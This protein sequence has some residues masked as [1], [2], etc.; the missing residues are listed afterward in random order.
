M[1]VQIWS[2]VMCPFCYIGKRRL[3]IALQD[4][5]QRNNVEF[6]YRSFQIDPDA[7]KNPGIDIYQ[8]LA[9]KTGYSYIQAK[10]MNQQVTMMA[11]EIGLNYDFD[12]LIPTNT[13]DAL[14]LSYFA[15]EHGLMAEMIERMMKAY[16][17]EGMDVG[18]HGVLADLAEEV[19]LNRPEALS[20]LNSNQYAENL[21]E[22]KNLGNRLSIRGVPH[23]IFNDKYTISGAQPLSIFKETLNKAWQEESELLKKKSADSDVYCANGLCSIN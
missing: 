10:Q 8:V 5:E 15:K 11:K 17:I 6:E 2:D 16:L 4:F 12:N 23:F 19:D 7:K 20:V 18:N 14:R 1:K 13:F 21:S 9:N 3:E 22:D